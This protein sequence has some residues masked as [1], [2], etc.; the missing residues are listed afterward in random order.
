MRPRTISARV[1]DLWQGVK[2]GLF[3]AFY[4]N[5]EHHNQEGVGLLG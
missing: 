1:D 5:G 2:V 3:A 4:D